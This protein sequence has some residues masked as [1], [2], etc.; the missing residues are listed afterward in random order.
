MIRFVKHN[1]VDTDKWDECIK[2]SVNSMPYAFSWYLDIVVERWDA[3]ILNDYEA[4]FPL[5][6]RRK[7]GLTYAYTPFWVQQLGLFSKTYKGLR[8]INDFI[9][10]IP[11]HYR[12]VELNMN[13]QAPVDDNS[14]IQLVENQNCLLKLDKP[15]QDQILDYS[16]NLRRNLKKAEAAHLEVFKNDAPNNLIQLFKADKGSSLSHL[17]SNEYKVLEQV[18]H[19]AIYKHCGQIWMAYDEGNRPIAGM[20]LLFGFNRIVLLFTGNSKEGRESAA[21]PFLIDEFLKS[22][23]NSSFVFDFEGSNDSNLN[24]FYKSF[25]SESAPYQTLKI[26]RL[27]FLI[28]YLK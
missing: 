26:N 28:K 9:S 18:M 2:N 7:F 3:L 10:E 11:K 14:T 8:R 6:K 16:S 22:S 21:M 1:D 17:S 5:P 20:F 23:A 12:F 27:P 19:V 13:H 4:V 15:Y 25:G 24:R